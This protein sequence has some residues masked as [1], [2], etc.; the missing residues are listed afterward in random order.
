MLNRDLLYSVSKFINEIIYYDIINKHINREYIFSFFIIDTKMC[1]KILKFCKNTTLWF[2]PTL[3]DKSYSNFIYHNIVHVLSCNL[4]Y[5]IFVFENINLSIDNFCH[6]HDLNDKNFDCAEKNCECYETEFIHNNIN[7]CDIIEYVVLIKENQYNYDKILL[8]IV[9]YLLKKRYITK[10]FFEL[11]FFVN[12]CD[13]SRMVMNTLFEN[14]CIT[15]IKFLF[16]KFNFSNVKIKNSALNDLIDNLYYSGS[17]DM[18][19]IFEKNGLLNFKKR[20]NKVVQF[21]FIKSIIN[22]QSEHKEKIKKLKYLQKYHLKD[23]FYDILITQCRN[24]SIFS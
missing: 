20:I 8:I 24:Y 1:Q 21:D 14:D 22:G 9:K 2:L 15:T 17:F 3:I 23:D 7:F 10:K 18:L 11:V 4:K 12:C 5:L 19:K 6:H 13:D 16:K